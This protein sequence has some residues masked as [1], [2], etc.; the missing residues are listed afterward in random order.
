MIAFDVLFGYIASVFLL[1]A[2]PGPVIMLIIRNASLYGFKNALFTGIGTNAASLILIAISIAI[3]L[4]LFSI[5]E[6]LLSIISA[7]GCLFIFYLGAS[8]FISNIKS[9]AL[10]HL[11]KN[12]DI[13]QN[14]DSKD[15]SDSL[16]N[17]NSTVMLS[18][19]ETSFKQNLDSSP[20]AQ[21]DKNLQNKDSKNNTDSTQSKQLSLKHAFLQGFSIAITNPKDI[22]FFLAFFPQFLSISNSLTLSFTLLVIL[23]IA[24]DF[25]IIITYSLLL[26]KMIFLRYKHILA[27]ISDYTLMIVGIAGLV[28]I[29]LEFS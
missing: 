3:I 20:K 9:G 19:S 5:T 16:A 21:N 13:E 25:S 29:I 11:G 26:Q 10:K 7:F 6:S 22:L 27:I 18:G 4:G 2:T 23:W 17:D 14:L 24:L 28:Y 12:N 15:S 8:S 1:I